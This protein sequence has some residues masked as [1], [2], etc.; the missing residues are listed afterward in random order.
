MHKAKRIFSRVV[1][2]LLVGFIAVSTT[3]FMMH[4]VRGDPYTA[5]NERISAQAK[6]QY[7]AENDLDKP[8]VS[9]YLLFL[10]R[11]LLYGDSGVSLY[12]RTTTVKDI[13]DDALPASVLL[14]LSAIIV[15][16]IIG[17][18]AGTVSAYAGSYRTKRR[19]SSL[20]I[21]GISIPS[22]VLAPLLQ[23][24]FAVK[25]KLVPV[26]GWG[27]LPHMILPVICLLPSTVATTTKYI[28]NGVES[29]R[30]SNYYIASVQ[31][32]FSE[33]YIF[34]HHVLKNVFTPLITVL[35][36][37]VSGI[38]AGSFIVEKLFSIP[39]IGRQFMDAV[40]CRDYPIII[41]LN[42]LVVSTYV[43][44]RLIGDILL[45]LI[46]PRSREVLCE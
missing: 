15:G 39:G 23:Y 22:F 6:E 17:I 20:C 3:F 32:G 8:L 2:S 38:F 10:R 28:A 35:V 26:S 18:A 25:L 44:A 14:G 34:F 27:E 42:I 9:Q 41:G 5:S 16:N 24:I 31:R 33:R 13:V 21:I 4:C 30:S 1:S 36:S 19:L 37:S 43:V 11:L 7:V 12:N 40:S 45:E 46:N 29:V